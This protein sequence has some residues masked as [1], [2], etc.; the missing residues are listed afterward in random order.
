[1]W[2]FVIS[3]GS[4]PCKVPI[5]ACNLFKTTDTGQLEFYCI[6]ITCIPTTTIFSFHNSVRFSSLSSS[7]W[8]KPVPWLLNCRILFTVCLTGHYSARILIMVNRGSQI[9]IGVHKRVHNNITVSQNMI[10]YAV[11]TVCLILWCMHCLSNKSRF[12]LKSASQ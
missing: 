2:Q 1:M 3:S 12:K 9:Y 4:V 7:P 10:N 11:C 8:V 6:Y 5:F